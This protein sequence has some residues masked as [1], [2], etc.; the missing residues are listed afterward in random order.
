M[1]EHDTG[2]PDEPAADAASDPRIAAAVDRLDGLADLPPDQHAEVYEDV[3][4]VLQE[5]LAEAQGERP[6]P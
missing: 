2:S 5:S 4:R 6:D 1:S 3:H